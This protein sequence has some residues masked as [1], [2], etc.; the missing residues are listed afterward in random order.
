MSTT[1]HRQAHTVAVI[2]PY[3]HHYRKPVF[4]ELTRQSD[5]GFNYDFYSGYEANV[6]SLDTI[7]VTLA[8]LPPEKGG[9]RWQFLHNRWFGGLFLWQRGVLE[10]AGNPRYDTVVFFGSMYYL[11]TWIGT[12]IAKRR[13]KRVLMWTHG[14]YHNKGGFKEWVRRRFYS[15][16]DGL[17]LYGNQARNILI[18]RG[19]DA[20]RLY[21]IFN[22]LD[23][24]AQVRFR[25]SQA[26]DSRSSIRK[27]LFEK[28]E[29]PLL[30]VIGRLIDRK[31]IDQLLSAMAQLKSAGNTYNLIIVG[32]GPEM[33]NLIAKTKA[34]DLKSEICFY[35]ACHE[36]EEL[37]GLFSAADLCV[38]P[39]AIGLMV[40]HAMVY[41]LPVITHNDPLDQGPEFE[42]IIENRT[43]AFFQKN[44][45]GSLAEAIHTWLKAN[46]NR[47][48]VARECQGIVDRY[49]TPEFQTK[50][51]NAAVSGIP[52]T[53]LPLGEGPYAP[54]SRKSE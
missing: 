9:L 33:D 38:S 13:G 43:G 44:D 53:S 19:V 46:R 30:M 27:R 36:E 12:L 37:A 11:S 20:R 3:L 42:A 48:D 28:P 25:E 47:E 22:S 34:M 45:I 17:L 15:L 2:Y 52:A 26:R 18:D 8:N 1:D 6:T 16:A 32:A 5:S 24:P 50:I 41:G 14:V 7:D 35:G 10:I 23:H 31:K 54:S 39:G 21:V 49:Y 51:I 29:K 4:C 40:M